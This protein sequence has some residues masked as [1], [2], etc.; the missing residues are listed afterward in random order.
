MGAQGG[1]YVSRQAEPT[2]H[3]LRH[4]RL[5]GINPI[6]QNGEGAVMILRTSYRSAEHPCRDARALRRD[7][8]YRHAGGRAGPLARHRCGAGAWAVVLFILL[9]AWGT[10]GEVRADPIVWIT[11]NMPPANIVDGPDKGQGYGDAAVATALSALTRYD[12]VHAEAPSVRELQMMVQGPADCTR[13]LMQSAAREQAI[14][15]TAPFGYVL[16][17][18]LVVRADDQARFAPYLAGGQTISLRALMRDSGVVLGIAER[19]RYGDAIDKIVA[20]ARAAYPGHTVAVY[21]DNATVTLLKM[22]AAHHID[23]LLAYPTEEYYLAG[24]LGRRDQYRAYTLTDAPPLISARFSC[25]RK[26]STDGI[27]L[28]LQAQAGTPAVRVAYQRVYERWLPPNLL[29]LYRERLKHPELSA[30]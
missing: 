8:G 24:Q 17:V 28:D 26:P 27:F 3:L 21:E 10:P 7:A 5:F 4:I 23:A 2:L 1:L 13:D 16:P 9:L 29:P 22:L 11:H 6:H 18:G 20:D 30:N 14:R 15:F 25:N 19:R 12:I